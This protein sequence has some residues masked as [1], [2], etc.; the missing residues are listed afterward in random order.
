[1]RKITGPAIVALIASTLLAETFL[2]FF[3]PLP[4]PYQKYKYFSLNQVIR[5]DFPVDYHM[6]TEVEAGLPG[7]EGQNHFSTNNMGFRG[8]FLLIPKAKNEFRI[9]MI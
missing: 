8:D 2:T 4:D 5:S 7:I 1:M 3:A 9:F 6:I